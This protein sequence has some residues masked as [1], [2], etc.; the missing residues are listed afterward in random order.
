MKDALLK[1]IAV[2]LLALPYILIITLLVIAP[3]L[4]ILAILFILFSR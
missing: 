2:L 4:G 3:P 1:G